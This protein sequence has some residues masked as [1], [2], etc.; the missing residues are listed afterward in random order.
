MSDP[1]SC[2]VCGRESGL[3]T[4]VVCIACIKRGTQIRILSDVETEFRRRFL[5][6]GHNHS[7]SELQF[8][9]WIRS[10][11]RKRYAHL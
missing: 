10:E 5:G 3:P 2:G 9:E 8:V 4:D 6:G 11:I 1:S 7:P